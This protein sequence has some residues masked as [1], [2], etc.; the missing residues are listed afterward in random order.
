MR[1]KIIK[2]VLTATLLYGLTASA[3]AQAPPPDPMAPPPPSADEMFMAMDANHDGVISRAEFQ[4]WYDMHFGAGSMTD[5]MTGPMTGPGPMD[6]P[7]TGEMP[8]P[9]ECS[10]EM[11]QS[12][13]QPQQTNVMASN[14]KQGNLLFRT[15]CGDMPGYDQY[16]ISLPSGRQAVDFGVE[17]ITSGNVV[18]GIRVEGG[19]TVYHSS[20]GKAALQMLNLNAGTYTVYLDVAASDPGSRVTVRFIDTAQ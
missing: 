18:F 6:G 20:A 4:A 15:V 13:Q 11:R 16:A 9:P 5:P 19:P 2:S 8:M 14:G 12:E 10:E 7:M 17:A 3:F 1:I